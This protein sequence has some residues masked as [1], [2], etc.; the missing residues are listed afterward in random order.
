ME[1]LKTYEVAIRT[2]IS[3]RKLM[4][5]N[6]LGAAR[7]TFRKIKEFYSGDCEIVLHEKY[8]QLT[9]VTTLTT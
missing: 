8:W 2:P 1:T 4:E 9:C 7:E 6:D 5:S 3:T